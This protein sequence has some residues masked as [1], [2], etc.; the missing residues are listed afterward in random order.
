M[1]ASRTYVAIGALVISVV[2]VVVSAVLYLPAV[3]F[4]GRTP[5]HTSVSACS[6]NLFLIADSKQVF[7]SDQRVNT[8]YEPTWAEL[9]DFL[10]IHE[11]SFC[12]LSNGIPICPSGG[13]YTIGKLSEAPKCSIGGRDHQI[14]GYKTPPK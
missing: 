4:I 10:R 12:C 7:L 5:Y 8:S 9:T 6:R 14:F 1:A 11:D 3:R 2:C 13:I